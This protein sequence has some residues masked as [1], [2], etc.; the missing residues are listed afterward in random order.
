MPLLPRPLVWPAVIVALLPFS[1]MSAG[2]STAAAAPSAV[3]SQVSFGETPGAYSDWTFG[4]SATVTD[5]DFRNTV[6]TSPGDGNVY[7]ANQFGFNGNNSYIG[8]QL[9]QQN[10]G[11]FLWSTWADSDLQFKDG[12]QGSHCWNNAGEGQHLQCSNNTVNHGR[13]ITG[14]TYAFRV[15]I[16]P[17]TH[18]AK[19]TV[20][21]ETANSSFVLG[22]AL[23]PQSSKINPSWNSWV[24][25]FDWNNP[26]YEC[27][28]NAYAKNRWGKMTGN[29]GTLTANNTGT[30]RSGTCLDMVQQQKQND[31]TLITETGLG[32][33]ARWPL[34][35]ANGACLDR[36]GHLLTVITY[37]CSDS[38]NS[39]QLFVFAR[40]GSLHTAEG[41]ECL[42]RSS[43]V[44]AEVDL[45]GC[46]S[47]LASQK[48]SYDAQR[49][50]VVNSNGWALTSSA[51]GSNDAPVTARP[52]DGSTEQTIT[53]VTD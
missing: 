3:G 6:V 48:W 1:G 7:W 19:A 49:K 36:G 26:Y 5:V 40:D 53:P 41:G 44:D 50:A 12:T 23:L 20:T 10:D 37:H 34:R 30:S 2:V 24:E 11:Q 9:A 42:Q 13:P 14:H 32:Q 35:F 52:Y 16:N 17:S 31:G 15:E 38:P 43:R 47:D 33:S 22:E 4:T 21:D 27:N 28:D 51:S 39:N 8:F 46:N 29:K 45:Y 25:Y 18:W